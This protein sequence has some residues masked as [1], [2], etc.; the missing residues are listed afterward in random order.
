MKDFEAKLFQMNS[1]SPTFF[2]G[3]G[4][5]G[6][7]IVDRIAGKIKGRWN[8][9]MFDGLMH[10]FAIDTNTHD[11]DNLRNIPSDNRI[12]ISDFDKQAYVESK[13]GGA[14]MSEDPWLT[15]WV[16]DWYSFRST[17]GAGA[18]Q[19]RIESRLCLYYQLEQDRGNLIQRFT[20]AIDSAK[21]HDN[22]FRKNNP[23]RFNVFV[24]GSV[25]GGTG[26]GGFLT[27]ANLLRELITAQGWIPSMFGT[28]LLP[29][30][31]LHDVP[32][33]L[34]QDINAN[35]YAALKELEHMMKL[36]YEEFPPQLEF[37]YN[38]NN[39][40][41]PHIRQ[42]PFVFVYIADK[43]AGFEVEEYKNAIADSAYIQVFSPIAGLQAADY[44]NYEKR[45]KR[46]AHGYSVH[47]GSY[48][49][50]VLIL[51][52]EDLLHYCALRYAE[53]AMARYLLFAGVSDD[54]Q[55]GELANPFADPKF[56][57]LDPKAQNDAI[58]QSFVRFVR[59]LARREAKDE[60]DHGPYAAI[61]AFKTR[62]GTS[63]VD[64]FERLRETVRKDLEGAVRLHTLSATDI[65][66]HNLKVDVEL[67]DLREEVAASRGR[68][69]IAMEAIKQD[70][71]SGNLLSSFFQQ[72][73]AGP[74]AQR[75]FLIHL[76]TQQLV[77]DLARLDEQLRNIRGAIDLGSDPIAAEVQHHRTTLT[78]TAEYTLLER[79]KGKNEDFE[80]ARRNLIDYF[81]G[82]LVDGNRRLLVLE[83][84]RDLLAELLTAAEN[85][86][87]SFRAVAMKAADAID[88]VGREA[89]RFM[90]TGN[91]RGH[92]G[93]VNQFTLDVELLRSPLGQRYWD[94]YF[95]DQF[96]RGGRDVD[97]FDEAPILDVVTQAFAPTRNEDGKRV[98]R[99]SQQIIAEIQEQLYAQGLTRLQA[100]ICG[101]H[102]GGTGRAER[103]L[104]VDDALRLEA[105]YYT[106]D[107]FDAAHTNR[108]P[109]DDELRRYTEDK[110]RFC[111]AKSSV[112]A[113]L[114]E[115][116]L[117]DQAATMS[118]IT[119]V[120]LHDLYVGS[121]GGALDQVIPQ[122]SRIPTWKDEKR[123]VFYQARLGI[124]LYTYRG[125]N[126][127]MLEDYRHLEGEPDK[128]RGY[129]LH[130]ERDWE[131]GLPN[132]DPSALKTEQ[133]AAAEHEG[134]VDFALGCVLE[135]IVENDGAVDW[136]ID[137]DLHGD[138]GPN[139]ERA[140]EAFLTLNDRLR[141]HLLAPITAAR[142]ALQR[143]D[144][145]LQGRV[146]RYIDTLDKRL[147]KLEISSD[148]RLAGR[149]DF[150]RRLEAGLKSL[151]P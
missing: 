102:D 9:R 74:L 36:G 106:R 96:L 113:N 88:A 77:D 81:N 47:Y 13:R 85:L 84:E 14:H 27:V 126:E 117:A 28:L 31:F 4:G 78:R 146:D 72:H 67:N 93:V 91:L 43:S 103:G 26:S 63:L 130:I 20:R 35:G 151:R 39:K 139:I 80:V 53:Q 16:H 110:L 68:V 54:D 94:R 147:L 131:H 51:P 40:R 149:A 148:A 42:M 48:G 59:Y 89:R 95:E 2:I 114:D 137:D 123:V 141:R 104:L 128:K 10:F 7:D 70:V 30:L 150:L 133:R 119:L 136:R 118:R 64:E 109:T 23:P 65:T 76:K 34:R 37:H 1:V 79:F 41:D 6:S 140:Y 22:P 101:T 83:A 33:A 121:L 115:M 135:V 44:D 38:P 32:G 11:L 105:T 112:M 69:Q 19:I 73:A 66:E 111:F 124:P 29:G 50:S 15:Q 56:R 134:I 145:D 8:A 127:E 25:A 116:R 86:L 45:Q 98:A 71:K 57:R 99:D 122:A 58:D 144:A 18:G 142:E 100:P 60:I 97:L 75:Y 21:H 107:A 3:L 62:T 132:L 52:D 46:L 90:E 143:G 92:E 24:Y 125:L 17:R 129:P 82:T 12:L 49:C 108:Q 87:Q 138:L 61:E 55:S 5:S 120:G